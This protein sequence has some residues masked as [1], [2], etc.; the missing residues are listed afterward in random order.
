ML[1]SDYTEDDQPGPSTKKKKNSP[2][3][4]KKTAPKKPVSEST[5]LLNQFLKRLSYW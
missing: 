3:R 1:A 2:K 5:L 4:K